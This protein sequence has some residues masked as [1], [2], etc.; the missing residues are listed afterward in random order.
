MSVYK[1]GCSDERSFD[2][3]VIGAGLSGLCCAQRLQRAGLRVCVLEA[4]AHVGGRVRGVPEQQL[5]LCP[6]SS[7]SR[8]MDVDVPETAPPLPLQAGARPRAQLLGEGCFTFEV[9][10]EF[11]H[12][13]GTVLM[14]MAREY[15]AGTHQL[16][17]WG[18]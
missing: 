9:G 6:M 18:G 12:G 16:F 1:G 15:G 14:R 4:S 5:A 17:T 3:I 13:E 10:G 7:H 8:W 11:I 2:V